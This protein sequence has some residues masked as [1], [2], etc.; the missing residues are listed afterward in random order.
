MKTLS[1]ILFSLCVIA[2]TGFFP[3]L[4]SA[5]MEGFTASPT[6]HFSFRY[7][8]QYLT[9]IQDTIDSAEEARTEVV[10]QLGAEATGPTVEV[11]FARNVQEMRALS[12]RQPPSYA[13]AVAFWPDNVI[14]ISLTT[15]SHRP[16]SLE[17]VFRHELAHLALRWVVGDT[18]V[19]RWFNEGL[20]I[21]VSGEQPMERIQLLWPT[22]ARGEGTPFRR[23]DRSFPDHEFQANRAY[24]ESADIVRFLSHYRGRWRLQELLQRVHSGEPFYEAM[25]TTW[26]MSVRSLER[27]WYR[28]LRRR[29][30]VIPSVTAGLTLWVLVGIFA[31]FAYVKRRR[32]IRRRIAAMPDIG[33][34]SGGSDTSG[35]SKSEGAEKASADKGDGSASLS[36]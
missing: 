5:E 19:P 4:A 23:L 14:V 12:P 25:S 32:D 20:A 16:V 35:S 3:D 26:G 15:S 7:R 24:A 2:V 8:P 34:D 10:E 1:K 31:I 33:G 22:A 28:D 13:D 6:E 29:Y 17:R 36:P 18:H 30:S 27:E 9:V 21:M 11:R